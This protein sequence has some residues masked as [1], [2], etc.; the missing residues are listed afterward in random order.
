[1]LFSWLVK[2]I[3]IDS[4]FLSAR[5]P[6]IA[7]ASAK[8]LEHFGEKTMAERI[9]IFDA[10]RIGNEDKLQGLISKYAAVNNYVE[11]TA[12]LFLQAVAPGTTQNVYTGIMS[13][14]LDKA[15]G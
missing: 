2:K 7:S 13:S 8:E 15:W 3:R 11:F 10:W 14:W 4:Y 5:A 6:V 1:M 9:A 12:E